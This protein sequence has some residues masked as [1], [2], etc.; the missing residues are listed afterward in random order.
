MH[1]PV[2]YLVRMALYTMLST[3]SLNEILDAA[4]LMK[5]HPLGSL[6]LPKA[7]VPSDSL[8]EALRFEDSKGLHFITVSGH[9]KGQYGTPGFSSRLN[10]SGFQVTQG[11]YKRVWQAKD[12]NPNAYTWVNYQAG[13]LKVTDWDADGIAEISFSYSLSGDGADP[14]TQ[15]MLAFEGGTKYAIRGKIPVSPDDMELY[16]KTLD[17]SPNADKSI[18]DSMSV[19]WDNYVHTFDAFSTGED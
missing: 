3:L 9:T 1:P 14:F 19:A 18:R 15:K 4:T 16:T 8:F 13:T 2:S 17:P 5:G 6:E 12:F 11:E 7:I 10:A